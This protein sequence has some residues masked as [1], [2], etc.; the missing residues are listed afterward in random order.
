MLFNDF[1]DDFN[2]RGNLTT[3]DCSGSTTDP[4]E[5]FKE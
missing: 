1:N 2:V 3:D 5:R 4:E